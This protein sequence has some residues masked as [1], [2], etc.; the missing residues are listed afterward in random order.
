LTA[1]IQTDYLRLSTDYLHASKKFQ[2]F[3]EINTLEKPKK[4]SNGGPLTCPA[5]FDLTNVSLL[6]GWNIDDSDI[7]NGQT[8]FGAG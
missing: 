8:C 3:A 1:A 2:F 7:V 5:G 6:N 4:V